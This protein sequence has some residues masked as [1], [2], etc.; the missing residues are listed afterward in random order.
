MINTD[1]GEKIP[2]CDNVRI[3]LYTLM[4]AANHEYINII[5]PIYEQEHSP[6]VIL[7]E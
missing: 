3:G 1:C 4:R 2:I 7:I 5:K 6:G